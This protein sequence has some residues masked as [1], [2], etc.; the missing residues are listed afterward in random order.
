[1]TTE[2]FAVCRLGPRATRGSDGRSASASEDVY[3]ASVCDV[4]ADRLRAWGA[5]RVFGL[6]GPDVDPLV[7]AL[8]GGVGRPE[9][10]QARHA[11]SAALMA[12]AH[13]KFTGRVGC[14]V[15]PSGSGIPQLLSGLYDAA[16]DR[17]PVVA[18]V[19][20]DEPPPAGPGSRRRGV[21]GA[22]LLAEVSQYCEVVTEPALIPDAFDRAFKSA[23]VDRGVATVLVSRAVL[24]ADA[25]SETPC[26]GAVDFAPPR[27]EP[28]AQDVLRAAEILNGGHR[29]AVVIGQNGAAAAGHAVGVAELLGAGIAKTALARDVLPDGL[30][31][32][33]GVAALRGSRVAVAVLRECDTLLLVGA[34]DVDPAVVAPTKLERVISVSPTV[35]GACEPSV[36][37]RVTGDVV[38]ALDALL[39]LL[40]RKGDRAWRADI[41]RAVEGWRA[42][43]RTSAGRFFGG[44]VN[45]RSVVAELSARLPDRAVVIPDAGTAL[46]WWTRHLELRTGMRSSLSAALALPGASVPYAVAA[47]LA[48]PERAVVALVGDGALQATGMNELITVRRH[49][50]RLAG[51]P[52]LVFCVLNNH[53]LNRLTWER[54]RAARDP[55]LASSDEAPELSYANHARLLGLPAVRCDQPRRVGET[56]DEVLSCEG[57]VVA[58]FVVDPHEPPDRMGDYAEDG[59]GGTLPRIRRGGL[60]R[61]IRA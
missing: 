40:R 24:E 42:T 57:P 21:P 54:R 5:E 6:P 26:P 37:A 34:E 25:P 28:D 35:R 59:A 55:L 30:P 39:P 7:T 4:V 19:G 60:L 29:V 32:V 9:F 38:A 17:Q 23:L 15:T 46:D 1:M 31:G 49:L 11:E 58:E 18:L 50:D 41:D 10:V 43:G 20:H 45:P 47:R 44:T 36:G 12:C 53:D 61:W 2:P 48:L 27:P 14:C 56:W 33:V 3:V 22:R 51:M 16:L 8:R 52:P 13:A